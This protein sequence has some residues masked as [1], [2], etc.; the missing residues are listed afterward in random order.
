MQDECASGAVPATAPCEP[1]DDPVG[2]EETASLLEAFLSV[3]ELKSAS[4]TAAGDGVRVAL[5]WSQRSLPANAHRRFVSSLA[6]NEAVLEH[7]ILDVTPPQEV[8]SGIVLSSPSPCGCY[9]LIARSPSPGAADSSANGSGGGAAATSTLLEVWGRSRLVHD[10]AVPST[11][12][13]PVMNDG[14][15]GVG[16]A[17]SPDGTRVV[18]VAEVRDCREGTVRVWGS[19]FCCI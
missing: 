11:L 18:Y 19:L 16:A 3:P 5:T 7:G 2:G 10:L 9:T 14:W 13:G 4:T 8:S 15:F 17:W 6:L 12:H 1:R